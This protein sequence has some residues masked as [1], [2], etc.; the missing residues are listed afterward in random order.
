M[1][2]KLLGLLGLA[3]RGGNL[4][5]G[6]EPVAEACRQG[7]AR[8]VL[9][10]SDAAENSA[11]RAARWA[12]AG[13]TAVVKLSCTKAELGFRLGRNSCAVL[14]LT[15]LGLAAAVAAGLA[16]EDETFQPLARE[17]AQKAE[18]GKRAGKPRPGKKKK[19]QAG[20]VP[21]DC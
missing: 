14:A 8:L 10:A 6:E 3:L 18:S 17:L 7:R 5:L 1:T 13:G 20:S 11:R 2:D 15:D 16:G 19:T 4:A 12:Q 9:T 21:E